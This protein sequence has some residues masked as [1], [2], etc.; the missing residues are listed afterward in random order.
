MNE[1]DLITERQLRYINRIA[2]E[3]SRKSCVQVGNPFYNAQYGVDDVFGGHCYR[4]TLI[5]A[6]MGVE[7]SEEDDN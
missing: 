7:D 2:K 6:A 1:S 5:A 4:C 3:H